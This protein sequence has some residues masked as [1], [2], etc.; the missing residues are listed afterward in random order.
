MT[1]HTSG[2][3]G[4]GADSP[5]P[6][7]R[8]GAEP[9]EQRATEAG[10]GSAEST[11]GPG[12]IGQASGATAL[13]PTGASPTAGADPSGY[14]PSN[15][16]AQPPSAAS[17]GD[18]QPYGQPS[19]NQ[20]YG[21]PSARSPY[22]QP[23][24]NP[25]YEQPPAPYGQPA[26]PYGQ[27]ANPYG[28]PSASQPYGQPS[29]N[30]PYEQPPAY[31]QQA[32]AYG[33]PGYDQTGYG[34][35]PYQGGYGYPAYGAGAVQHPQAVTAL[36]TGIIGAV[37]CGPVGIA[38]IVTG[39]K[40]RNEIDADPRRYTGRGMGTAGLILGIVGIVFT[41]VWILVLVGSLAAGS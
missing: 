7:S 41:V 19:A 31:D 11:E 3:T 13:P 17:Y 22:G 25:P 39:R 33:T 4:Q 35:T 37:L 21:Q 16:P 27:Q 12:Q 30:P 1:D 32:A 40:V 34:V 20:P 36:V 14:P 26:D 28:Q 38:G 2:P 18:P 23:S 24:A 15:Q 5:N 29:A 9:G 6:F 8:E 10:P